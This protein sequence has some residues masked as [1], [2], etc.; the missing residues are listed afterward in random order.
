MLAHDDATRPAPAELFALT[1]NLLG[2]VAG[3][4]LVEAGGDIS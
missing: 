3:E 2:G 4:C 1:C